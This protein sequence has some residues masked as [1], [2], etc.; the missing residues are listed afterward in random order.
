MKE[1]RRDVF[2][3]S[4]LAVCLC[5]IAV[6]WPASGAERKEGEK[7]DQQMTQAEEKWGIRPVAIR[8]TGADHFLDFRYRVTDPEKAKPV[9][10]RG[11]K[12]Y[13]MD[14]A[15]GKVYKVTVNKLGPM[16]GT[17]VQP[18][19]GKQYT[20][21]FTN[22]DSTLKRGSKVSIIIGD[23]RLEGLTLQ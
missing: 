19:K 4:F 3:I 16:R 6:S 7:A 15:S 18:K 8:L 12:T 2:S 11:K 13:L 10:A 5:M 14:Q 1:I 22:T 9:L 17:T 20:I 23:C 21:L